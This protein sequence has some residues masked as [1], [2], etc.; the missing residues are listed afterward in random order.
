[1]DPELH[2]HNRSFYTYRL[3]TVPLNMSYASWLVCYLSHKPIIFH[4][5][6]IALCQPNPV[7]QFLM[8]R[9]KKSGFP[10]LYQRQW[11]S[12]NNGIMVQFQPLQTLG[13]SNYRSLPK[14]VCSGG[15]GA[16]I[17]VLLEQSQQQPQQQQRQE[18]Q[19][20]SGHLAAFPMQLRNIGWPYS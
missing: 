12:S 6:V 3:V 19:C 16:S 9:R 2:H 11:K 4:N 7:S 10:S 5:I 14:A 18:A 17:P 8:S 13:S 1:M 20:A 15:A